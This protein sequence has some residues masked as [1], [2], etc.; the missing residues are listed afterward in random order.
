MI[1][2]SFCGSGIWEWLKVSWGCSQM[3]AGSAVIWRFNLDWLTHVACLWCCSCAIP[4]RW[5][6]LL[7][8]DKESWADTAVLL[9]ATPWKSYT[10]TSTVFCWLHILAQIHCT[11]AGLRRKYTRHGYQEMRI[12]GVH[13]RGWL[14]L[15]VS[16]IAKCWHSLGLWR[17]VSFLLCL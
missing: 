12:L 10:I 9:M 13:L 1:F 11:V 16:L 15:Y 5:L 3:S 14:P 17:E 4:V 6:A 2:L 8:E 7:W